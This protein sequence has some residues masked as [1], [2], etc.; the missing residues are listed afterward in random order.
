MAVPQ[1]PRK[2]MWRGVVFKRRS[3]IGIVRGTVFPEE[4]NNFESHEE[5]AE[6]HGGNDRGLGH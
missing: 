3:G 2:W 1:M 5:H 6:K 4:E